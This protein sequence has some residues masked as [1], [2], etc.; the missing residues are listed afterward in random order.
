ML[1][2]AVSVAGLFILNQGTTSIWESYNLFQGMNTASKQ[3]IQE[4]CIVPDVWFDDSNQVRVYVYNCGK[5]PVTI[6]SVSFNQTD[7]E[8]LEYRVDP[9]SQVWLNFTLSWSSGIYEVKALTAGGNLYVGY[10]KT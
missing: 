7:F 3:Q 6:I 5:V 1:I 2:V 8:D 9:G 10:F 4:R